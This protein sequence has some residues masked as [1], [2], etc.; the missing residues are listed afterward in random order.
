MTGWGAKL[1]DFLYS[2]VAFTSEMH[3]IYVSASPIFACWAL[4]LS[5]FG[6]VPGRRRL[7]SQTRSNKNKT[8]ARVL[9]LCLQFGGGLLHGSC[10]F[11][12]LV[13]L[14]L[15]LVRSSVGT[16]GALLQKKSL[17]SIAHR[18]PNR[19]KALGSGVRKPQ[20]EPERR[21]NLTDSFLTKHSSRK[22][23]ERESH[24]PRTLNVP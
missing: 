17:L 11:S 5:L 19:K 4:L 13:V 1:P 7:W 24:N 6:L 21:W 18:C 10:S 2:C 8:L 9:N 15:F 3:H 23:P 22:G 14:L 20:N 12:A 16:L